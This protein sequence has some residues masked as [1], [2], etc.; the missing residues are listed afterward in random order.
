MLRLRQ[1]VPDAV[2]TAVDK[3]CTAAPHCAAR[4]HIPATD[5]DFLPSDVYVTPSPAKPFAA[6]G[7][8]VPQTNH[9]QSP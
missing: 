4:C 7:L 5:Y 2:S 6:F 9:V 8:T 3:L 1:L